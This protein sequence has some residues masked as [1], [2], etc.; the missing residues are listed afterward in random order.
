MRAV[1]TLMGQKSSAV[2]GFEACNPK[3]C[4]CATSCSQCSDAPDAFSEAVRSLPRSV[5]RKSRG[6]QSTALFELAVHH[7]TGHIEAQKKLDKVTHMQCK[8][9]S[10]SAGTHPRSERGKGANE[11]RQEVGTL[12]FVS[13]FL[14]FSCGNLTKF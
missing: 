11:S 14:F 13:L 3:R 4:D 12:S 2:L 10:D 9:A 6:F 8:Y 5:S 1:K 7:S